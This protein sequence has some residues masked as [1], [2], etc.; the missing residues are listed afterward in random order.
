[1][2][3]DIEKCAISV[4]VIFLYSVKHQD[5]SHAKFFGGCRFGGDSERTCGA[6]Q[7]IFGVMI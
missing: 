7:V 2:V 4:K 6:R 3:T 1:M 5:G